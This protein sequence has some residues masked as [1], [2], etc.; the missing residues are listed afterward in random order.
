VVSAIRRHLQGHG[1]DAKPVPET[2][3]ELIERHLLRATLSA[4]EVALHLRP[5]G[6]RSDS[7]AGARATGPAA[8]R[9]SFRASSRRHAAVNNTSEL[10][11][12]P[13]RPPAAG[14]AG[15]SHTG[16]YRQ[17]ATCR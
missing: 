13:W 12:S 9:R 11:I 8:S 16:P 7:A 6:S 5:D 10:P 14:V 2:D 15:S 3:R 17:P 1:T 4:T